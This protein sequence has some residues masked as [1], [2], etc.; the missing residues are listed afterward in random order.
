[1]N[2]SLIVDISMLMCP[3]II[4]LYHLHDVISIDNNEINENSM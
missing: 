1:M 3:E 4:L 2:Y